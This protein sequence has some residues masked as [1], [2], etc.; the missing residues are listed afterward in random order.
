[1]FWLTGEHHGEFSSRPWYKTKYMIKIEEVSKVKHA[2]WKICV[3]DF[4]AL[5]IFWHHTPKKNHAGLSAVSKALVCMC[6][7]WLKCWSW[8]ELDDSP[9]M[10]PLTWAG[11]AQITSE[12]GG[13]VR[14]SPALFTACVCVCVCWMSL[15]END[16]NPFDGLSVR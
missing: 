1:M 14:A 6:V 8:R 11:Q 13:Q 12:F 2:S 15:V 5:L 3:L 16:A 10:F 4:I 9:M 7:V